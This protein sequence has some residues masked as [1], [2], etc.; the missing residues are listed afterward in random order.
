MGRFGLF[1]VVILLVVV[2]ANVEGGRGSRGGSSR[3]SSSSSR[4]S[5]S[6]S[7]SNSRSR[8]NNAGSRSSSNYGSSRGNKYGKKKKSGIKSKLKKAA[9]VGVG[10]WAGYKVAK[11]TAKFAAWGLGGIPRPN[12]GFGD[13]NRW[14]QAEGMLCRNDNDC[15]WLDQNFQ[16]S[17][18]ELTFTPSSLWFGGDFAKIRGQCE[19]RDGWD[20]AERDFRCEE[21]VF[22]PWVV[23]LIVVAVLS[24]LCCCCVGV[25]CWF[26]RK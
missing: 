3:G 1:L 22:L 8:S 19:C 6:Y 20:W 14:R 21:Q 16:C 2:V 17:D 12:W 13:W 24:S 10:V 23:A 4:R 9:I 15:R 11:A 7:S 25:A 26:C 5:S 18:Y